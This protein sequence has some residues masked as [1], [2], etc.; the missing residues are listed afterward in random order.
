MNKQS[1]LKIF[2]DKKHLQVFT[3]GIFSGIPLFVIYVTLPAWLKMA[4]IDLAVITSIAVARIF[5]S[6]KFIWAPLVDQMPLPIIHKIGR[7]KSWMLLL[8]TLIAIILAS[9]SLLK[10]TD[11]MRYVYFLTIA[12]GLVSATLDIAIDA[13]RVDIIEHEELS[14]ATANAVF[15]YRIGGL[16]A[17]ALAFYVAEDYGW[18]I[19]FFGLSTLY[20]LGILFVL[21]LKELSVPQ[22]GKQKILSLAFWHRAAVDPFIDF[23]KRNHALLILSAVIMY[24][25]GSAMLGVVVMPFYLDLGFSLKE[26]ALITKV[27]A[28]VATILGTYVGGLVVYKLGILRGMIVCGIMQATKHFVLLWL[29]YQG[30]DTKALFIAVMIED[31]V[32]GMGDSAL[33]GYIS[34]LCN[35]NFSATQYA[36]LSSAAGLF[37]HSIVAMGGTIAKILGW[38]YYFGMTAA[39]SFPGLFLLLILYRKMQEHDR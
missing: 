13:F 34:Y 18:N 23:F 25:L 27:F 24:K 22:Y 20:V 6:L 8:F 2:T 30:H 32:S 11:S 4:Q 1:T 31:V 14:I 5:Y 19:V 15:G 26:I 39:L 7:R 17:G 21:T 37:S 3:L 9:Y 35:K 28:P 10:P 33:V 16:I 29:S 38:Q 36:L 12:L